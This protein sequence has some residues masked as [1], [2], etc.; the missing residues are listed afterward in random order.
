VRIKVEPDRPVTFCLNLRL[1]GWSL[2]QPMP[3]GL[4]TFADH[5]RSRPVIKV[6]GKQAGLDMDKGFARLRRTWQSGDAV[7][8]EL[9]M[10][11]RRVLARPEVREDSGKVAIE[12][13]PLVYCFEAVDNSG[14]A[15]DRSI[16]DNM[17]FEAVFQPE[18]LGGINL[19]R[20]PTKDGQ[21][22]LSAVPYYAWSH[23]GPGQMAVW[24]PRTVQ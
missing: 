16:P 7:D 3:G 6:N 12:R 15:L 1:P 10:S 8:L 21:F 20:G 17:E 9:P 24:L 13:G 5:S 23:R 19:L 18:L 14:H 4:Y 2:G 11:V 22:Q